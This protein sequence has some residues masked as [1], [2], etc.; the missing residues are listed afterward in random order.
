MQ[1]PFAGAQ[2]THSQEPVN[3]FIIIFRFFKKNDVYL[4]R[5][6]KTMKFYLIFD[7]K[8]QYKS[9]KRDICLFY[10]HKNTSQEIL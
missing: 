6:S 10:A 7:E 8:Y 4:L 5:I 2:F 1:E 9:A 3:N